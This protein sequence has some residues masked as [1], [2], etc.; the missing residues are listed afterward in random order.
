MFGCLQDFQIIVFRI[1]PVSNYNLKNFI[2]QLG[3]QDHGE[4]PRDGRAPLCHQG[5]RAGAALADKCN[6]GGGGGGGGAA[7]GA[8]V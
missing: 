7:H 2:L 4:D 5:H 6:Q 8:A 1:I 3:G